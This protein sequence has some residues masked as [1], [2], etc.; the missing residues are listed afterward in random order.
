M[1]MH[2]II[3]F[4]EH[5]E[6]LVESHK[7]DIEILK[8]YCSDNFQSY[9][10]LKKTQN[11]YTADYYIGI[12]WLKENECVLVVEPKIENLDY[13]S[14]FLECLKHPL[15]TYEINKPRNDEKIYEIFLDKKPVKL[16]KQKFQITPLLI[17]HF[18]NVV[19]SIV[20][21]GLKKGYVKVQNNLS[22]KVKG[23]ILINT[24]IKHNHTKHQF[25]K[26]YCQYE[27][28]TIDC[29]EN[30]I[31]KKALLFV[32][33]YLITH[34]ILDSHDLL[35]V[36]NQCLS[37][38]SLVSDEIDINTIKQIKVNNFYKEYKQGLTLALMIL[39]HFS[40]SIHNTEKQEVSIPPFYINMPLLFE[41]YVYSKLLKEYNG[42]NILYQ[43]K[44]KYGNPDFIDIDNKIIFDAKYKENYNVGYNID[45]IRQLSGYA[46]D[47]KILEL[48]KEESKVIDCIIFYPDK[49]GNEKIDKGMIKN[50][51]IGDFLCFY[52]YCLKLPEKSHN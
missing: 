12:E 9:L 19:N 44:A 41:L 4:K 45:D 46:R 34:K 31:L 29:F 39:K 21:K 52:K 7:E 35:P 16:E 24:T 5:E 28:F 1:Q 2:E 22:N 3:T 13:L 51:S 27:E 10:K 8:E 26:T 47:K 50:T 38:F 20:K 32:N 43:P 33:K 42:K 48:L 15:V 14:M 25:N 30:S 40:Y 37:A 18:L 17:F 6:K 11:G 49:N 36:L 23:K